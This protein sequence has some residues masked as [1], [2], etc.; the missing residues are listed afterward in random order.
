MSDKVTDILLGQDR[1][2]AQRSGNIRREEE[3]KGAE[4][5]RLGVANANTIVRVVSRISASR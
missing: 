2:A 1:V 5:A 4:Q 3:A